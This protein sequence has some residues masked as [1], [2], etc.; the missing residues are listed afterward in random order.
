MLETIIALIIVCTGFFILSWLY[1][2][3]I[4]DRLALKE[5]HCIVRALYSSTTITELENCEEW[6]SEFITNDN[7]TKEETNFYNE[8]FF[9]ILAI[10][11]KYFEKG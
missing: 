9:R 7:L 11:L 1:P 4:Q 3:F 10:R 5:F 8:E 6:F 2:E